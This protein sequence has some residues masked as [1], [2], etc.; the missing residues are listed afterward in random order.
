MQNYV[1]SDVVVK[2]CPLVPVEPDH[3]GESEFG[4]DESG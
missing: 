3:A 4:C 1:S 2:A